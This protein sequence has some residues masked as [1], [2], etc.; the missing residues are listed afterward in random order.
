MIWQKNG[1]KLGDQEASSSKTSEGK[2]FCIMSRADAELDYGESFSCEKF[3]NTIVC[4]R[5][6]C[7]LGAMASLDLLLH[8]MYF[9]SCQLLESVVQGKNQ[10]QVS[11]MSLLLENL[12]SS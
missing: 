12:F 3:L 6:Y 2:Q 5:K 11:F 10:N 9:D 7:H 4:C 1:I 8:S